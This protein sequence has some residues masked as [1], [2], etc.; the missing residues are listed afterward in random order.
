ME[1]G[2]IR[3][4]ELADDRMVPVDTDMRHAL[5]AFLDGHVRDITQ[6][7]IAR[8]RADESFARP[9]L[10]REPGQPAQASSLVALAEHVREGGHDMHLPAHVQWFQRWH[11]TG[12]GRAD[13]RG[14]FHALR[15][16]T[17]EAL[18]ATSEFPE[19]DKS[20]LRLLLEA[21]VRNL[22]LETSEFESRR[23]LAEALDDRRR[24][25]S[26]FHTSADAIIIVDLDSL[27]VLE[28]NPEAERLLE[29]GHEELLSLALDQVHGDLPLIL[30]ALLEGRPDN[31]VPT[32]NLPLRQRDGSLV[33]TA[34]NASALQYSGHR[35][36][37]VHLRD[38]TERVRFREELERRAEA[39]QTELSGQLAE[40]ERMGTF[41]ENVINALPS[42]VLV[43]DENLT[44]LH[45]NTAYLMQRG[46][47]REEVIG[48]PIGAVFPGELLGEAGLQEAMENTL[49]TGDRVRWAGFRQRT[50]DHAERILN[51]GLDPC[52]GV[53]GERYLLVTLEDVTE[54][55]RQLYERSIMHQ[56]VQAMLGLQDLPRL[57]H[58]ILTGITAGGAVGLGFNRAIMLLVDEEEGVLRAE[59]AVGPENAEEAAR[60]WS[61]LSGHRTMAEFLAE[62]DHLP[63]P[64]RRPLQHL[65]DQ[66]VFPLADDATLPVLA[67]AS[68][69]TIHVLDAA[70]DERV[71]D[72]LREVL[73]TDEFVVAPMV[74]QDMVIGVAI[75]DN[76]ISRQPIHLIDVQLLTALA[77]HAALAIQSA[78]LYAQAERRA[79]ELAEAYAQLEAATER[80]VRSET[81]AAIGEVTAI[82]AHE[83][84]NP[85]S[86]IGGFA[87]MLRR[88]AEE[89]EIV[90]RN[91]DI[92]SGEVRKLEGILSELLDFSKPTK[93]R[94][95]PCVLA[96]LVAASV[97]TAQGRLENN[98]AAVQVEVSGDLPPLMLDGRQM[99]QVI[100]NL[101][102]NAADAMPEGGTITVSARREDDTVTLAVADTGQGIPAHHLDQIFDHF[103]TTKPTGTG[104]GLALA[105]KIVEDHGA[106]LDVAS[107]EGVGSTFS[108]IFTLGEGGV[109]VAA[110]P[111]AEFPETSERG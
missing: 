59:M 43:L 51:I 77:N 95:E 91:A 82:V 23:L 25:E 66:L 46:L 106:R 2:E 68:K 33:V 94:L 41:L 50:A 7:W 97:T 39:L 55:H 90:K 71:P 17:R 30:P 20:A 92:I 19:A 56:I 12:M 40:L 75:A 79:D 62:Y 84:R 27:Q 9:Y 6:A 5:A 93:L 26:L 58:A 48:K 52:P 31:R 34:V 63:P 96:D 36:A 45:A 44:V 16:I 11:E 54:R 1:M 99:Q 104:L 83:I 61:E 65:V 86:T 42:R 64:A 76:S 29:R 35:A 105:K 78:W 110:A 3:P 14:Q 87:N 13:I 53:H 24:Y 49:A 8:A 57:L 73:G 74:V 111:P 88:R 10:D 4:E 107:V 103:F 21:A 80:L 89:P 70:Y 22:R 109:R 100:S 32:Y 98:H 60:V 38:V 15:D 67:A 85:L 81:L 28:A 18:D 102:I 72:K 101:I 37:Q 47:D 69:Q 108:I